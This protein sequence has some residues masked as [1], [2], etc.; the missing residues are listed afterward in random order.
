MKELLDSKDLARHLGVR[1]S[2][3]RSMTF[4]RQIPYIKIGHLVRFDL[5]EISKWLN[6][7]KKPMTNTE[8][9]NYV[10]EIE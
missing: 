4:K 9:E 6:E 3:V 8:G 1:L 10:S 7:N 5:A 2:W